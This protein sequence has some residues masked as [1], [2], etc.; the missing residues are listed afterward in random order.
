[1]DK[2]GNFLCRLCR[3]EQAPAIVLC[4]ITICCVLCYS[5]SN[6]IAITGTVTTL[7]TAMVYVQATGSDLQKEVE[8]IA[9]I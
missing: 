1:M 4:T 9:W 5:V 6:S 8:K 7:Y 3:P 2:R